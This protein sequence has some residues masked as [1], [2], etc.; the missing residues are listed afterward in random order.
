[1]PADRDRL[2]ELSRD[3]Y[4]KEVRRLIEQL[5]K[6]IPEDQPKLTLP[7]LKFHRKIGEYA[8]QTYSVQDELLSPDAYAGHLEEVLPN[9]RDKERLAEI[10]K[11]PQWVVAP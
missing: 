1:V 6:L 4:L 7:G 2:N 11:D 3:H 10:F 9:A 5:N 8:G